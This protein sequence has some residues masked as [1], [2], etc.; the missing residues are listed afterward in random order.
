MLTAA[1]AF[2]LEFRAG[3]NGSLVKQNAQ[4]NTER[5]PCFTRPTSFKGNASCYLSTRTLYTA[6]AVLKLH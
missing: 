6:H 5:G 1:T 2:Q 4:T 3:Q